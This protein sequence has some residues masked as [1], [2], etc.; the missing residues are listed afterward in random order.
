VASLWE[1]LA[2]PSHIEQG[3][4]RNTNTN[5]LAYYSMA[6]IDSGKSFIV[7]APE[8]PTIKDGEKIKGGPN[9]KSD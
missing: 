5:A 2:L 3:R 9:I 8:S 6:L 1:A 4:K 7:K